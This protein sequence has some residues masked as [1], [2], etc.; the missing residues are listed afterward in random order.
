MP[1]YKKMRR[2]YRKEVVMQEDRAKYYFR[3]MATAYKDFHKVQ[4]LDWPP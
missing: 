2:K 3:K 1:F 4:R